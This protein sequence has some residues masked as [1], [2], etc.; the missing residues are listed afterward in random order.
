M[1]PRAFTLLILLVQDAV[2]SARADV[3]TFPILPPISCLENHRGPYPMRLVQIKSNKDKESKV[4]Y[5]ITGQGADSPPVGIF[6]IERETGWLKVT[7]QLDREKIDRYTLFSHA[8]SAS[9]QPVEDPMEI[10]I[11]VMDQNDNKPMFIKEVFV[12]YIEENAKPGTSVMTVNATDADDAVNTD[13]G[14]VSY[15][16][17]SQQPPSPHPQMFTIDP[18]RGIISVL[19]TGLDRETTPNYTL[20]VQATDQEGKGLSS[21]ATAIIE[22]TDANNPSTDGILRTTKAGV[23]PEM[24]SGS[25]TTHV[26]NTA[27]GLPAAGL[28]LRLAQLGEPGGQWTELAQRWTDADGRCLP[29]LPPGQ[30]EAGTYKLRFETAAY[31]QGLGYTSFYPFVEV[32]FTITDPAQKLHVPLLISPYSYT[33]YRGS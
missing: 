12:G 6:V 16:I 8:V 24:P 13:N 30:A 23:K 10:I 17:V 14:I 29:L 11:T 26:L 7:E 18:A 28:A 5:S 22:V 27:T 1:S 9:G 20:I 15:S 4:Y 31:W 3:L 25:L 32:V 2:L 19:G 33:T 21:T